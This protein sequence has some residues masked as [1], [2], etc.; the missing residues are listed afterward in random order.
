MRFAV[1][2]PPFTDVS[3]VVGLAE[4]AEQ[5]GWDGVFLWDHLR[6]SPRVRPDV[7][8][9]WVLLGAIA[10]VTE[11]VRLGTLITPLARRRPWVVA[12]HMTT[13]DHLSG[14]RATLGVGL[15][16]PPQEDFAAFGDPANAV[17]RGQ[18]LDEGL[19]VLDALLRGER[20]VHHGQ[21][22]DVDAELTPPPIQRPRPPIWVG[23]VA[24]NARP[25]RRAGDWDGFVPIGDPFLTPAA[26]AAYVGEKPRPDWDVVASWAPGV[27]ADEFADAGATW[28][29]ESTDPE[30]DWVGEFR[31]RVRRNPRDDR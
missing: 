15:G 10:T 16:E 23:G 29:V 1:S 26:L 6:W 2:I 5:F 27:P 19:A 14:G 7:H 20:C 8:D 30:G 28:L 4:D 24:P 22:L 9:P 12:K 25:R 13:L 18:L 17:T 31:D 3:T 11:R 21:H